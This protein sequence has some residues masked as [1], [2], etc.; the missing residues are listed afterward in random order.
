MYAGVGQV[1]DDLVGGVT[2]RGA[3]QPTVLVVETARLVDGRQDR[4]V[5]DA[6]ELEVLG[7]AARRDVDDAGALVHRD[8]VPGDHAVLDRR[9]RRERVEGA[10]VVEPDELRAGD[11]LDEPLVREARGQHPL[12]VGAAP[13]RLL[14]VNRGGD[15][16]GQRPRCRRPD[17]ERLPGPLPQREPDE[18]RRVGAV[19]IDARLR[20]LVLRERRPT[21][22]A[23]LGGAMPHEDAA[24]LVHQ[25]QEAPDVLD[26]RVT[27]RE[28][29]GTPV[30]P[31]AEAD[32]ALRELVGGPDHLLAA[33]PRE[34]REPEL[35]DLTL[36]VEPELALDA[37]LDP[38][39]LAIEAVLVALVMAAH[40]LV[41][42]EDVLEGPTPRRVDR[43]GLVRRDRAVDE[44]EPRAL[45]VLLAQPPERLL[46]VPEGEYVPLERVV[47]RLVREAC[48]HAADSRE[49]V[50]GVRR[51][52][53]RV[54][55]RL[56]LE[57][58]AHRTRKDQWHS[59]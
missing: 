8:L 31:L 7:A 17:D 39:A 9:P 22:R 1:A 53:E 27:E 38:E 55:A 10:V 45:R 49:G 54:V 23:P 25:L 4:Q 32:R 43:E 24:A 21:A 14:R 44:A 34:L 35:L 16:R 57:S 12:A 50:F 40:R 56:G 37:D 42:L 2:G 29:V 28:V 5:V 59:T 48:E 11:G 52:R 58:C 30:H 36:R 33:T 20:E 6:G 47:I 18:E 51:C 46:P 15:V 19:L 41:A 26:V 13:V 3:V